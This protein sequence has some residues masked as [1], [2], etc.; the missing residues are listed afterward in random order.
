MTFN[1]LL[2]CSD[3]AACRSRHQG[4][5]VELAGALRHERGR[6]TRAHH[7]SFKT[8]QRI[9]GR[10]PIGRFGCINFSDHASFTQR[11]RVSTYE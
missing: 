3:I 9:R 11:L 4:S 1:E 8:R 6:R 7:Y 10:H 2:E 5:I